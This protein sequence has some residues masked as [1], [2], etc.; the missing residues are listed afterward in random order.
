MSL[1]ERQKATRTRDIVAA[2]ATLFGKRGYANTTVE[3]VAAAAGVAPGT[4][5]N[6]FKSKDGLLQAILEAHIQE[7]KAEREDFFEAMPGDL[8][9]AVETFVGLMLDR[10]FVLVNREIWRQILASGITGGRDRND[11]LA[12]ITGTLVLQFERLFRTFQKQGKLAPGIRV[13]DL[14]EAAM[15][16]ADFHFYRLARHDEL[17]VGTV[18]ARIRAQLKLLLRGALPR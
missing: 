15:G 9:V 2:A 13:R 5:Y 1:R 18:K 14:A 4:I 7:R 10:A 8:D 16:I 12:E 11:L 17:A 6:Y 3:D